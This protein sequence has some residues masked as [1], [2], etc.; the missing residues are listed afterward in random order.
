MQSYN[1][2]EYAFAAKSLALIATPEEPR[3]T[4][5]EVWRY[6]AKSRLETG[7]A[8]GALTAANNVLEVED[9]PAW[10]A[11]GLLD[12]GRALLLL[13]RPAEARESADD[14]LELH[15]Q[16][17]TSAGLRILL[18]D[19]EM[20]ASEFRKAAKEYQIVV[21]FHED[22]D[23]KPLALSKLVT[24]FEKQGDKAEADR[25]ARQLKTEFPDW[26]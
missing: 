20:K 24:A 23:L 12:R 5:K 3:A 19:L 25:Y 8:E 13:N 7:D 22:K 2:G 21:Q 6:L 17:R 14:A 10:K 18:G 15:P 4:P 26:K 9:N 1:A 16:G 11:D